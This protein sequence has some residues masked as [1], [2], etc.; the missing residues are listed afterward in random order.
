MMA[1]HDCQIDVVKVLV[2]GRA[3]LCLLDEN[4]NGP[5]TLAADESYKELCL[6]L[7][8]AGCDPSLKNKLGHCPYELANRSSRAA[9]AKGLGR[10]LDRREET[11]EEALQGAALAPSAVDIVMECDQDWPCPVRLGDDSEAVI[12]RLLSGDIDVG[13]DEEEESKS[14]EGHAHLAGEGDLELLIREVNQAS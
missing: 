4:G 5:L 1:A 13:G 10:R 3:D 11:I 6:F 2:E 12:Q 9:M 8:Q 7:V 14:A